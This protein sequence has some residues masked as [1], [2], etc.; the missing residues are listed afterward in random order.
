MRRS[1]IA[2]YDD[3]QA[4]AT[5]FVVD[6]GLFGVK[7]YTGS[8]RGPNLRIPLVED[9]SYEGHGAILVLGIILLR[10][11]MRQHK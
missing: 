5:L 8:K 2:E 10:R 9:D 7:L 4:S 6:M 3:E 11:E 1:L